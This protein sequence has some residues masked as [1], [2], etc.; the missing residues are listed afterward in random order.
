MVSVLRNIDKEPDI[1]WLTVLHKKR[2]G[3]I[4]LDQ[5]ALEIGKGLDE[6]EVKEEEE[7]EEEEEQIP[8]LPHRDQHQIDVNKPPAIKP[9]RHLKAMDGG[10]DDPRRPPSKYPRQEDIIKLPKTKQT[11]TLEKSL[12]LRHERMEKARKARELQRQEHLRK[13]ELE[14]E[15]VEI[16]D[17]EPE[18]LDKGEE[19]TEEVQEVEEEKEKKKKLKKKD[20]MQEI[21]KYIEN[22]DMK[23]YEFLNEFKK[24]LSGDETKI[25]TTVQDR[26][27]EIQKII[28]KE[29][30]GEFI[31]RMEEEYGEIYITEL[32]LDEEEWGKVLIISEASFDEMNEAMISEVNLKGRIAT[33]HAVQINL[34]AIAEIPDLVPVYDK[35]GF[36]TG[37]HEE[38]QTLITVVTDSDYHS[39][40]II[41]GMMEKP[42][43]FADVEMAI[44]LYQSYKAIELARE[45][46]LLRQEIEELKFMD[47]HR[48]IQAYDLANRFL[49]NFG[50]RKDIVKKMAKKKSPSQLREIVNDKRWVFGII[51]IIAVLAII[52]IMMAV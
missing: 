3:S 34:F 27:I 9:T 24:K 30:I 39:E 49:S 22:V 42:L 2:V 21:E 13:M 45:N 50:E 51:C 11:E 44:E 10:E 25:Y 1:R 28:K 19:E 40:K 14:K 43:N 6:E 36:E 47:D 33:T 12:A 52:F 32:I 35:E 8:Q 20:V 4:S 48:G 26:L 23:V 16:R 46:K 31:K 41:K 37:E 5:L 38:C 7:E 29:T 15:T 17:D 18:V